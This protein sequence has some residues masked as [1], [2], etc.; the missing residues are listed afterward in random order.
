MKGIQQAEQEKGP[1]QWQLEKIGLYEVGA[2]LK[3]V[4]V[5]VLRFF[6]N[7]KQVQGDEKHFEVQK[8]LEF[9]HLTI[10]E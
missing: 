6:H 9:L 1:L 10:V 5:I 7:T 2:P 8:L 3:N 4:T